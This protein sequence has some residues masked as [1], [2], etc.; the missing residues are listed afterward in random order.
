MAAELGLV[1][2]RDSL[3]RWAKNAPLPAPGSV[4]VLGVDD[5]A[6]KKG[7]AYGTVLVDLPGQRG[8]SGRLL[9]AGR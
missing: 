6:F 4:R 8:P 7:H 3:L 1:V 9:P 2:G 5:F